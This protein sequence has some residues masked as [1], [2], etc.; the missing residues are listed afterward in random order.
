LHAG[1][2]TSSEWG[3]KSCQSRLQSLVRDHVM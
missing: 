1:T 2:H 3:R